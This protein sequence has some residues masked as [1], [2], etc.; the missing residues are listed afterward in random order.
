MTRLQDLVCGSD[1]V[2]AVLS[3]CDVGRGPAA[4][5]LYDWQ[6]LISGGLAVLAAI[7]TVIYVR[8]QIVLQ[9][10]QIDLQRDQYQQES[11]QKVK[12][13]LIRVPH[14]LVEIH[15]YLVGCYEAWKAKKPDERPKPQAAVQRPRCDQGSYAK[16]RKRHSLRP[17]RGSRFRSRS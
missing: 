5:F 9:Q 16:P 4:A 10:D 3:T 14:A 12:A 6:T 1:L 17:I 7:G 11:R 13:A 15:F 2:H 8:Q